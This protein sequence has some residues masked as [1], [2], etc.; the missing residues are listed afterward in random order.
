MKLQEG[1]REFIELLNSTGVKYVIV[2]G[3]AVAY[4]GHPRFTG[5]IDIFVELSQSN[6]QKLEEAIR[7]FGF[8]ETG[9]TARDFVTPDSIIQLGRPPNR[10]DVVTSADA[11]DFHEA[12]H[13]KN[14][15]TLDG[16][17][18]YFISKEL[19]LK[20]KRASGRARDLADVEALTE[21]ER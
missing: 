14:E 19:L 18:V 3:Y 20:N 13:S 15:A 21:Q 12:W 1:L 9:L 16:L 10:I 2:G 7:R 17:P 4:H 5:D 8:Q 11:V 6:A